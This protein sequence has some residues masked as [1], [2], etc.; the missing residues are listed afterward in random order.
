LAIWRRPGELRRGGKPT[1]HKALTVKQFQELLQS[2]HGV[3]CDGIEI[4][5]PKSSYRR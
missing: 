3:I 4:T 2:T 5:A 1:P